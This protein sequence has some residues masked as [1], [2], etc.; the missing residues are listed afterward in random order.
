MKKEA[1]D[2]EEVNNTLLQTIDLFPDPF[3]KASPSLLVTQC[4]VAGSPARVLI[5]DGAE[6]SYISTE[7]CNKFKIPLVETNH[8]AKMANQTSQNL[9]MTQY[10]VEVQMKGYTEQLR[11][12]A[13]P[14]NYDLILGKQWTSN[15]NA[16]ID[17]RSNI[18]TF[19]HRGR[20]FEL[21]AIDPEIRELVSAN[22]IVNDA[23]KEYPVHAVLVR[24]AQE[25]K[26]TELLSLNSDVSC[27]L[28]EFS[29]VFPEKLPPG[30]PP[31]R[32]QDF[33]IELRPGSSPQ[34][35]GLYR[36]STKELDELRTQLQELSEQGFIRP[37]VSPWASPVLFV[38][39]K[40]GSLR[41]CVDY[42]ALN[43]LTIKTATHY[44]E[45]TTFLTN[46]ITPAIL[47]R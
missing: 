40:D 23:R 38:S 25:E 47:A 21:H 11:L 8:M 43:R 3:A 34:K 18:V 19:Q 35:K 4:T 2:K 30:L 5:D 14:L 42:R 16:F 1:F 44:P 33:H 46:C 36:M 32:V 24:K 6:I 41:M 31:K 7:F 29:D 17:C 27:L 20:T 39:K 10:P 37:S 45:S 26:Q 15:H 9:Q 13:S 28:Q 12:A 22:S